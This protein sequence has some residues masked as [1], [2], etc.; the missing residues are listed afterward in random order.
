MLFQAFIFFSLPFIGQ[1]NDTL[2]LETGHIPDDA[3]TAS[4][5]YDAYSTG[6]QHAR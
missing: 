1:C 4:S 5:S 2:G 6:P 3:L